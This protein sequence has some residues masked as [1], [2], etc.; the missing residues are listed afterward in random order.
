MGLTGNLAGI[1]V[2][3]P[4][5]VAGGIG[6]DAATGVSFV[7]ADAADG[8]LG[9]VGVGLASASTSASMLNSQSDKLHDGLF[10][11]PKTKKGKRQSAKNGFKKQT[12]LEVNFR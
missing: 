11:G 4:T 1:T 10:T 9:D 2:V 5:S 8:V 7:G 3:G 12:S 6:G